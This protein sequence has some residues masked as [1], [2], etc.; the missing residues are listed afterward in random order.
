MSTA[1]DVVTGRSGR[2]SD[3]VVQLLWTGVTVLTGIVLLVM[4]VW[5]VARVVRAPDAEMPLWVPLVSL[6]A[7]AMGVVGIRA[8]LGQQ[9]TWSTLAVLSILAAVVGGLWSG[10]L[11]LKRSA[12]RR[13]GRSTAW[14]AV[15]VVLGGVLFAW[16]EAL[17]LLLSELSQTL[18]P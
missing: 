3:E 18:G 11:S 5:L 12:S 8:V 6:E 16:D 2:L 13:A 14:A 1:T 10:A 4:A 7:L 9:D 15:A 17:P